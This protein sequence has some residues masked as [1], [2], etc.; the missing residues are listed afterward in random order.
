MRI[1]SYVQVQQLY[2][3]PATGKSVKETG[4]GKFL[5]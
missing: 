1:D 5:D 2:N 4:K 3:K